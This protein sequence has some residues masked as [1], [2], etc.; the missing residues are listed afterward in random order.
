MNN[1]TR[2]YFGTDTRSAGHYFWLLNGD[3]QTDNSLSDF[4]TLPFN[5]EEFTK[6]GKYDYKPKG[7]V[8]FHFI[9]GWSIC[10]ICGSP[11]DGRQGCKS[12]FFWKEELIQDQI[13]ER[14]KSI[15]IAMKI[16]N[17][18]PFTVEYFK[19]A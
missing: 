17:Q 11:I 7:S 14:I 12:V 6:V 4:R 19:E 9:E 1:I 5:P 10:A 2:N 15:P 13:I 18:M 3:S 16:I 8:E